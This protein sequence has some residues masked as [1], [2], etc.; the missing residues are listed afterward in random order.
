[1]EFGKDTNTSLYL[2]PSTIE[3]VSEKRVCPTLS[4][5]DCEDKTLSYNKSLHY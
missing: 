3:T 2:Q 4:S 1:M 5:L